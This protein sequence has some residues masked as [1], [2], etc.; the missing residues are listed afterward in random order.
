M[1]VNPVVVHYFHFKKNVNT[2]VEYFFKKGVNCMGDLTRNFS[3]VEYLCKC[4]ICEYSKPSMEIIKMIIP[5]ARQDQRLRDYINEK[6]KR[7]PRNEIRLTISS[8]LR[9]PEHNIRWKGKKH[10]RHLPRFYRV[11]QGASDKFS[12]NLSARKLRKYTKQAWKKK[13]ITGG[14]GLYKTFVHTDKSHRRFWG[15]W[16]FWKKP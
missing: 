9:C 11:N 12:T 2:V 1:N 3:I 10:S 15:R 7:D 16:M 8:G 14:C 6:E 4:G 5:T 13:I